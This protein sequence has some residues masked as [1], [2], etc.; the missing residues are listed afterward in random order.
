[1]T[2]LGIMRM[3]VSENRLLRSTLT[4]DV[5]LDA[6][7]W[8]SSFTEGASEMCGRQHSITSKPRQHS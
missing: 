3:N 2:A 5:L 4:A 6:G 8:T 1:M 7:R